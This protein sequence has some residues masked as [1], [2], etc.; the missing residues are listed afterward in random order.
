MKQGQKVTL[1]INKT[2]LSI[3][4]VLMALLVVVVY[5]NESSSLIK[6]ITIMLY[7]LSLWFVFSFKEVKILLEEEEP[8]TD[9]IN[10]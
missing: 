3:L 4:Q 7:F 10:S 6:G 2:R 1:K 9:D 5:A 8:E